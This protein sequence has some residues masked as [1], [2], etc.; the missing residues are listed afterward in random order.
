MIFASDFKPVGGN[1]SESVSLSNF[2]ADSSFNNRQKYNANYQWAKSS[3][4]NTTSKDNSGKDDSSKD[5]SG[6]GFGD[7]L[8]IITENTAHM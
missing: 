5:N 8:D 1:D 4:R 7:P 6:K 2:S 3:S